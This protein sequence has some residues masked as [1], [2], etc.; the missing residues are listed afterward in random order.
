MKSAKTMIVFQGDITQPNDSEELLVMIHGKR[1]GHKIQLSRGT[2]YRIGRDIKA[3]IA[4]DDDSVSRDHSRLAFVAGCW[5]VLDLDSTNG[6]YVNGV[7]IKESPLND[8]ALL[9]VGHTIFKFL[10]TTNVEAAYYE[11]IYRMAIFDG[12]TQ[13]YNRRYF[14]EFTDRE[15]S[16]C[17]RHN[18]PLSLIFF[19][20]DHFKQI[21]DTHGH[22]TGDYALKMMAEQISRRMRREELFARYAGDEFV[23]VLPETQVE[24]ALKFGEMVRQ[25]VEETDFA[26]DGQRIKVTISLGVAGL[27]SVTTTPLHLVAAADKA[28]YRAKARGRNQ[29]AR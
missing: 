7:S 11:E 16:R 25:I 3:D 28:L 18:R 10:S 1:I 4:L 15:I 27:S 23:I 26:F 6:T 19:D 8:G 12:L 5:R 29:V 20:I 2:T 24:E 14:E 13:I 21:N 9:K 22:L 17:L